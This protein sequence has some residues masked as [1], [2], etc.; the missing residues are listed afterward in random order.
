MRGYMQIKNYKLFTLIICIVIFLMVIVGCTKKSDNVAELAMSTASLW[1]IEHHLH[2]IKEGIE[3]GDI[4]EALEEAEELIPWIK[5]TSW[6]HELLPQTQKTTDAVQV[7]VDKL[8]RHDTVAAKTALEDL[9]KNYKHLHHK[10][11][12]LVAGGKASGSHGH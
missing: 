4:G 8:R 3:K 2:E 11:M 7:V 9:G 1:M 12:E 6:A 10:V 5:G